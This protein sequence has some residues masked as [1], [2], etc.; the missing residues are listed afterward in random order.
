MKDR[1]LPGIIGT[2]AEPC[3]AGAVRNADRNEKEDEIPMKKTFAFILSLVFCFFL[4]V[5]SAD[6]A[7]EAAGNPPARTAEQEN[8]PLRPESTALMSTYMNFGLGAVSG[9]WFYG[10]V[11]TA[12]NESGLGR[13]RLSDPADR[14]L[15]SGRRFSFRHLCADKGRI[16]FTEEDNGTG[17]ITGMS[18]SGDQETTLVTESDGI[19]GFL[20]VSG[21]QLYYTVNSE[22]ENGPTSGKLYRTDLDGNNRT[23]ILDKPVYFPYIIN[24]QL[25]Y[26]DDHDHCRLHICDPDGQNDRVLIDDIVFQYISDGSSI[27]YRTYRDPCTFDENNRLREPESEAAV[28]RRFD[29][30]TREIKTVISSDTGGWG[31]HD[32][33]IRYTNWDDEGRLYAF[34]THDGSAAVL[35]QDRNTLPVV[36]TET[37]IFYEVHND[38][39]E[40]ENFFFIRYDTND[41]TALRQEQHAGGQDAFH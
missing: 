19:I 29:L 33:I 20:F 38:N 36:F 23:V 9:D 32:G 31:L 24:G 22:P 3:A 40:P 2:V 35:A 39:G 16:F 13:M 41:K 8:A 12:K 21:D 25:V 37:G 10:T 26:Q 27:Y 28:I 6:T 18:A 4:S 30:A 5:S 34:D 14:M 11:F 15:L 1:D 7:A 17:T